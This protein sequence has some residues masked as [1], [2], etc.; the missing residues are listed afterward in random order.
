[1]RVLVTGAKEQLGYEVCK[2]LNEQHWRN[3][4]ERYLRELSSVSHLC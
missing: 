2:L 3:A 1:M 4:L